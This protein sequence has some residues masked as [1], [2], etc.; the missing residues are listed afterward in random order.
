MNQQM[1]T[2]LERREWDIKGHEVTQLAFHYGFTI[3]VWWRDSSE[4]DNELFVVVET[5]FRLRVGS[6][7]WA[8]TPGDP[9]TMCASLQLLHK[10]LRRLIADSAG[11]LE[12]HFETDIELIAE[13][14]AEYEAW[15]ATGKGEL[16]SI[17]LLCTAHDGPPWCAEHQAA[18][19]PG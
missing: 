17:R 8:C 5:P 9:T 16:A 7:E 18:G 3:H 10:P 14:D 2:E 13:R 4:V 1:G 19:L 11:R 6:Q 12:M 15:E